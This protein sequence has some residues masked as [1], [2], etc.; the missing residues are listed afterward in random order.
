M[1]A[2]VLKES[3]VGNGR[4][5]MIANISPDSRSSMET[6]NTLR[7]ADR[8]KAIGKSA[9]GSGAAKDKVNAI[10]ASSYASSTAAAVAPRATTA[11]S[12]YEA[13]QAAAPG[14]PRTRAVKKGGAAAGLDTSVEK[15]N[16]LNRRQVCA[17]AHASMYR[18]CISVTE[19]LSPRRQAGGG[20]HRRASSQQ[21]A[22]RNDA[23]MGDAS[24][25]D[26]PAGGG[27]HMPQKRRRSL[28]RAAERADAS[29]A[30]RQLPGAQS[31]ALDA[32]E[33]SFED[34]D[35]DDPDDHAFVYQGDAAQPARKPPAGAVDF[36]N[37]F[38]AQIEK[39]MALIEQEVVMLDRLERGGDTPLTPDNVEEVRR[40]LAER[41][42]IASTLQTSLQRYA[43]A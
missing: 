7:Y 20:G 42:D 25:D 34:L 16:I 15:E 40:L 39:S 28:S 32:S 5:V 43:S 13:R 1:D 21:A 12:Y 37:L 26:E 10:G 9:T 4:T 6:V 24:F 22:G 41:M 8:V 19:T 23:S 35:L 36:V 17:R 27:E 11:P 18:A 33:C 2:Q 38:R 29:T 30:P 31:L 14:P 3:F